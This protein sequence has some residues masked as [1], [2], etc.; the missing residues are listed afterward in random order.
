VP[1]CAAAFFS[2]VLDSFIERWQAWPVS[3]TIAAGSPRSCPQ[4]RQR[5]QAMKHT[6]RPL[7]STRAMEVV[8]R[9]SRCCRVRG[10]GR[11]RPDQGR[12]AIAP[13]GQRASTLRS[14]RGGRIGAHLHWPV[15]PHSRA[16]RQWMRWRPVTSGDR[17][18]P[19]SNL[20]ELVDRKVEGRNVDA[21]RDGDQASFGI[22][23]ELAEL[24]GDVTYRA[25]GVSAN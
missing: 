2:S 3:Q 20:R 9:P 25:A 22:E 13:A 14:S 16:G 5:R 1:L 6:S 23:R 21:V 18:R 11:C 17:E 15:A 8:C 24:A 7:L 10:E 12:G 19:L 4:G